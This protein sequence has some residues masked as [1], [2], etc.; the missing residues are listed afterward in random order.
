MCIQTSVSI[1]PLICDVQQESIKKQS[2]A[3]TLSD[4]LSMAEASRQEDD[5]LRKKEIEEREKEREN[6][7]RSFK[8]M[9]SLPSLKK[10]S[11]IL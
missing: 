10:R 1:E 8:S 4:F 2:Q 5:R 7:L 9:L 3:F 11:V 6:E